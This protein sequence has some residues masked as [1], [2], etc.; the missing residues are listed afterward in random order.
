MSKMGRREPAVEAKRHVAE[1]GALGWACV[2]PSARQGQRG[3]CVDG[4]GRSYSARR[5][6][7]VGRAWSVRAASH[8]WR[9][10]A[11]DLMKTTLNPQSKS[12]A[13]LSFC[14]KICIKV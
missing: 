10:P 6:S 3:T 4:H 1:A 9:A 13:N 11:L 2:L 5:P 14:L 12:A 7:H 8:L